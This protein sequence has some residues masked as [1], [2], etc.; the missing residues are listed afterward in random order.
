ME[1]SDVHKKQKDININKHKINTNKTNPKRR[2][3]EQHL[4]QSNKHTN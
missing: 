3:E 2:K 1:N 4:D